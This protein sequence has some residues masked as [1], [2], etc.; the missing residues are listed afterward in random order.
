MHK[1][2]TGASPHLQTRWDTIDKEA[3]FVRVLLNVYNQ[4]PDPRCRGCYHLDNDQLPAQVF[5]GH[6]GDGCCFR[7]PSLSIYLLSG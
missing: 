4:Y 3:Y 2:P 1:T 6:S 5:L 7:F